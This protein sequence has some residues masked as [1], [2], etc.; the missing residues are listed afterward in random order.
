MGISPHRRGSRLPCAIAG[1]FQPGRWPRRLVKPAS[2]AAPVLLFGAI[3][4]SA[5]AADF[6]A[7]RDGLAGRRRIARHLWRMGLAFW[8]A[9]ASFFL[10]QA[11]VF[12]EALR[13]SGLLPIPV[14]LVLIA[15]LYWTVRV[16]FAK[17]RKA[18]WEP[19]V[20]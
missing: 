12:P 15:V 5:G 17:G 2:L 11:K 3:A 1:P 7:M 18:S 6:R 8:I 20:A 4:L 9:T 13:N 16:S 19:P 14:V 10:G